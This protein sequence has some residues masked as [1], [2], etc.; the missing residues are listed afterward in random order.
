[1]VMDGVLQQVV[2][3]FEGLVVTLHQ[4]GHAPAVDVEADRGEL[5]GEEARQGKAHI[6]EAYHT[7]LYV[8]QFNHISEATVS[9]SSSVI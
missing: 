8:T 7:Y 2:L 5:G 1:M 4:A 6:S 9:I 3:H